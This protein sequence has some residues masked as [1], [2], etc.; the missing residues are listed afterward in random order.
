MACMGNHSRHH[1]N[2]QEH[3]TF[4]K[5]QWMKS[6]FILYLNIINIEFKLSV[7]VCGLISIW[8]FPHDLNLKSQ[9]TVHLSLYLNSDHTV[10]CPGILLKLE[11]HLNY[12]TLRANQH[13]YILPVTR[14]FKFEFV[15]LFKCKFTHVI[16]RCIQ[17]SYADSM[18]I[19]RS[20]VMPN[21]GAQL[22]N[23]VVV[24]NNWHTLVLIWYA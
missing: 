6:K 5:W 9:F 17:M 14:T 10:R 7:I 3:I 24:V 2:M 16:P 22:M 11:Q 23:Q 12:I 4:N 8:H 1:F 21:S 18:A 13:Q 15:V 19:H 20:I